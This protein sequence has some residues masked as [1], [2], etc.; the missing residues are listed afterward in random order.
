MLM[1]RGG[2][3]LDFFFPKVILLTQAKLSGSLIYCRER[4]LADLVGGIL[5]GE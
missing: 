1:Y 3:S 4:Y 5:I 2:Q